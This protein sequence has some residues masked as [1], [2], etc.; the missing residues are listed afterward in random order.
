[1]EY[2]ELIRQAWRS[3]WRHRSLWVLGLFAGGVGGASPSLPAQQIRLPGPGGGQAGGPFP[4]GA[5]EPEGA[6]EAVG[7]V[8]QWLADHAALVVAGAVGIAVLVLV[9][10][11]LSLIAQ[12]G[13][14]E[15]TIDLAEGRETTLGRAWETGRRLFWRYVGMY[16]ILIG[17][18]LLVA[19]VVALCLGLLVAL[20]SGGGGA[21]GVAV[22]LGVL[23]GLPLALLGIVA[24]IALGIVVTYAQRAI[25]A[26]D[27]GPLEAL[28]SG[29]SLLRSHPGESILVWLISL[30]LGVGAAV[31][32]G[33]I[34]AALAIPLVL[35]GVGLWNAAGVGATVVYGLLALLLVLLVGCLV[36]AVLNTFFWCYWSG[37][38]VRL[39][40]EPA[41][42]AGAPAIV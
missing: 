26:E 2:G 37:A 1:M 27:V 23:V 31:V 25:P 38:F 42:P 35:V 15:A 19:A 28:G 17:L 6:L 21:M 11:V 14:A 24:G 29:W 41:G 4:G 22:L 18:G 32:V 34:L 13:L 5:F 39:R 40:S 10:I 30:A 36:E 9:W 33:L 7:A 12:G 20:G 16:L 3:T 8:G